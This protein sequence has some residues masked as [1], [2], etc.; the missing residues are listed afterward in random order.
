MQV[1]MGR[2]WEGSEAPLAGNIGDWDHVTI[3]MGAVTTS[4]ITTNES[5]YLR[6]AHGE[7][8]IP[9]LFPNEKS[10]NFEG[11]FEP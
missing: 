5:S 6:Y 9:Q 2:L 11:S 4:K 10:E 8:S 7:Y 3:M 1:I